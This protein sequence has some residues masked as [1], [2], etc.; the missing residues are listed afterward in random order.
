M[1]ETSRKCWRRRAVS[2]RR[3]QK[4]G[5]RDCF[6]VNV[7]GKLNPLVNLLMSISIPKRNLRRHRSRHPICPEGAP[8]LVRGRDQS[9]APP[10]N[11]AST[12]LVAKYWRFCNMPPCADAIPFRYNDEE[13]YLQFSCFEDSLVLIISRR[14]W[15]DSE[16]QTFT[17]TG[18]R[19]ENSAQQRT[20]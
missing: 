2:P 18:D 7:H 13:P 12:A 9:C 14:K 4:A 3:T 10:K 15:S 16:Y 17:P 1:Y 5:W 20:H 8:T 6:I 11:T 19:I